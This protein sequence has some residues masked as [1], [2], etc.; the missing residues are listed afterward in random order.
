MGNKKGTKPFYNS[1]IPSDWDV[2]E[3]GVLGNFRNG[4]GS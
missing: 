2:N 3:L 1:E 4:K